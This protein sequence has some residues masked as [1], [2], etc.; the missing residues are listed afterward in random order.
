[1][2][3][4]ELYIFNGAS[5]AAAYGIGTYIDQLVRALKETEWKVTIVY[6][7]AQGN[8]IEIYQKD[9][10]RQINIPFLSK[11]HPFAKQ[12]YSTIIACLLK[13]I[14]PDDKETEYIFHLNFMSDS[15]FVN[16][17]KKHFRCKVIMIAHYT[18][19]SFLL[20]GDI[21]KLKRILQKPK[22]MLT[23]PFEK[24]VADGFKEDIKMI[25]RSDRLVCVA[26]H[27]WD[28][29]HRLG[30]VDEGKTEIINNALADTYK[31]AS[32]KNKSDLTHI[33]T[34]VSPNRKNRKKFSKIQA[35]LIG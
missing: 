3:N 6:L 1:M 15:Y 23:D 27:T 22:K 28:V 13:D 34:V 33:A 32:I 25:N 10:Y 16:C 24:K 2:K 31:P 4:K 8:E 21:H 5:R 17:L 26:L 9:E 14:I 19:W 11:N 20:L 12:Y 35:V 18:D 7:Y 29:F 30:K